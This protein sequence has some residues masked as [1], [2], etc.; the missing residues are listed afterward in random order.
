MLVKQLQYLISAQAAGLILGARV[1]II[2]TEPEDTVR[3]REAACALAAVL[4]HAR[5][6]AKPSPDVSA[7]AGPSRQLQAEAPPI[8]K[9]SAPNSPISANPGISGNLG[10]GFSI[11]PRP[12]MTYA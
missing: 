2:V 11:A 9:V 12:V 7:E 4:V 1:P 10:T 3:T 8:S 5:R 6:R